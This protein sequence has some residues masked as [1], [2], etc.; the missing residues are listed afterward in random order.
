ML[1][2]VVSRLVTGQHQKEPRSVMFASPIQVF[3][4]IDK[5]PQDFLSP[6]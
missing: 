3:T 1:V 5:I 4:D 6:G 2:P